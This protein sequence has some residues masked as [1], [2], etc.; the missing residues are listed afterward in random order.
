MSKNYVDIIKNNLETLSKCPELPNLIKNIEALNVI[1]F[2]FAKMPRNIRTQAIEF[3]P[4]VSDE[5]ANDLEKKI[6]TLI[7]T[8]FKDIK[9]TELKCGSLNEMFK[10]H[11][12]THDLIPVPTVET[13]ELTLK[14][15]NDLKQLAST[16]TRPD[17]D[18]LTPSLEYI[19]NPN[20]RKLTKCQFTKKEGFLACYIPPSLRT[21]PNNVPNN[22]SNNVTVGSDHLTVGYQDQ[23]IDT[24][25]HHLGQIVNVKL[26]KIP[27]EWNDNIDNT[28][29]KKYAYYPAMLTFS[30]GTSM[31]SHMSV[32]SK[33]VKDGGWGTQYGKNHVH[34]SNI[35]KS[36]VKYAELFDG[37]NCIEF[38]TLLCFFSRYH[39]DS[40]ALISCDFDRT[41]MH[42][43]EHA[44]GD[45]RFLSDPKQIKEELIT[46]FGKFIRN[47]DIPFIVTTSRRC[48]E[49]E[50]LRRL[51]TIAIKK[52]FP[53]C[54]DVSYGS[55]IVARNEES[56]SEEKARCK[57]RRVKLIH[58]DDE[59]IVLNHVT[60]C[61][62]VNNTGNDHDEFSLQ[63][64]LTFKKL[65]NTTTD[66]LK[67][68][69]IGPPGSGK[70][71][72][73]TDLIKHFDGKRRIYYAATDSCE[74][75]HDFVPDLTNC[76]A[77][78]LL[79]DST[80]DG[81]DI[82]REWSVISLCPKRD[83]IDLLGTISAIFERKNHA[84]LNGSNLSYIP[85]SYEDKNFVQHNK[86][87]KNQMDIVTLVNDLYVNYRFRVEDLRSFFNLI[88]YD[89]KLTQFQN[90]T[91]DTVTNIVSMLTIGY[92][93]G[94]QQWN[95]LWG[96]QARNIVL[97]QDQTG[98]FK[99][100]KAGLMAGSE[101]KPVDVGDSYRKKVS[102]VQHA[103]K[104]HLLTGKPL[105]E[106]TYLTSKVDGCLIQITIV[107][108]DVDYLFNVLSKECDAFNSMF[109]KKTYT[110]IN[111]KN[112]FAI[113]STNG[114]LFVPDMMKTTIVT[115]IAHSCGIKFES[116]EL[117]FDVWSRCIDVMDVK[118]KSYSSTT[119]HT[120]TETMQY[121]ATVKNRTPGIF[122]DYSIPTKHVE[123]TI[124]YNEPSFVF[125]GT[126]IG[127][128]KY[129]PH[130][131]L[132]DCANSLGWSQPLFRKC[133]DSFK[134]AHMLDD[135]ETVSM[136]KMS[137]A[138]YI[139]KW[140]PDNKNIPANTILDLEGFVMLMPFGD[141]Y[142]Y[143][144]LKTIIYYI[145]HKP[146]E[147]H[148][149]YIQEVI[150][151]DSS[152]DFLRYFPKIRTVMELK[153]SLES[154]TFDLDEVYDIVSTLTMSDNP[155]DYAKHNS[156]SNSNSKDK[157]DLREKMI[158]MKEAF[159]KKLKESDKGTIVKFITTNP[160][161]FK[162]KNS[163]ISSSEAIAHM[164]YSK[165]NKL[166]DVLMKQK[167]VENQI[168][169]N[170]Y[171][172]QN[173]IME[174]AN[175][176]YHVISSLVNDI[177]TN[178]NMEKSKPLFIKKITHNIIS[179]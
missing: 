22:G 20:N 21:L 32:H 138:D 172:K 110:T 163:G 18:I 93:E 102:N 154:L 17:Q 44:E 108:E 94:F 78:C 53:K 176:Y 131:D 142:T 91:S 160:N 89:C 42:S 9:T 168:Y 162:I 155:N 107:R 50:N 16:V 105:P 125:L 157:E 70:T 79:F 167:E 26:S 103:I 139:N 104:D 96:R 153:T 143:D 85:I 25:I 130:F 98:R 13:Y 46:G 49:D 134:I 54:I 35:Y 100:L 27:V 31:Y 159:E 80:G 109:M 60:G 151:N 140:K 47:L 43:P 128:D 118:I 62:V 58:Y 95:A 10:I 141:S 145:V 29:N 117:M 129:I 57:A 115:A 175:Q 40:K 73:I 2:K 48:N 136:G 86:Y 68:M 135:L 28:D 76:D 132:E 111:G 75:N 179:L 148:M 166:D 3:N 61:K 41:L 90:L 112:S 39:D 174:F 123:L 63:T 152:G 65:N 37:N 19:M 72:L 69:L 147:H 88:G 169:R 74:V 33:D 66:H 67:V 164:I 77:S 56:R 83:A 34:Q 36:N 137:H 114:T 113:I 7:K 146:R 173:T 24:Y 12:K 55:T 92:R 51:M 171:E 158:K 116:N 97:I 23:E 59:E 64:F 170:D 124:D 8:Y 15:L 71:T 120:L 177:I 52:L 149:D 5:K 14:F 87:N 101:I 4:Y 81:R 106:G 99:I 121:E 11:M 1:I 45:M 144:K 84:T 119:G 133:N 6:L 127:T 178:K 126:R 82:D 150:R 30:D 156:N 38:Q 122:A 161:V 165:I